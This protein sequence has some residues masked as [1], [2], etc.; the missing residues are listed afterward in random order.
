[1][2]F[3]NDI[4]KYYDYI[5]PTSKD[6]VNFIKSVVGAPPKA[7]L[8]IA[9]GTGGYAIELEKYGYDLTAV[10]LDVKM[11]RELSSK[12]ITRKSKI[13]FLQADMMN[14]PVMFE[15]NT[16]EAIYCI[17]NSLVHLDSLSEIRD[18]FIDV[19]KL[20]V[21]NG[22]FVFQ[23][24]NYNRVISQEVKSLPTIVNKSVDLKFER[25]YDYQKAI[26]KVI[27]KTILS[28]SNKAIQ[29]EINLTPL[30]QNEA[31]SLLK[32]AG[33]KKIT[34]YGDFNKNIFDK[35]NSYSLIIQAY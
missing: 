25:I 15:K 28:V 20:L 30:L 27:F 1:M 8:D 31:I 19:R 12:A 32:E 7:I 13:R 34:T 24:I 29:N 11:I 21:E 17:G 33:F 9:C 4:S 23:I 10:D 35:N 18:F 16:F 3:Y 2:T 26:N 5:F 22:V 6:T 14:L